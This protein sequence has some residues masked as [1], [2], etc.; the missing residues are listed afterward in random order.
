MDREKERKR[1]RDREIERERGCESYRN[2]SAEISEGRVE[3]LV[4]DGFRQ[5][6]ILGLGLLGKDV[7]DGEADP[8]EDLVPLEQ[9]R[10][11]DSNLRNV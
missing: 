8:V 1:E 4:L 2:V 9:V 11:H 3:A 7:D 6:G 10:V 5:V